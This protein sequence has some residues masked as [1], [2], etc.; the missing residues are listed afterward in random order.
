[1]IESS[2]DEEGEWLRMMPALFVV[3]VVVGDPTV[4][5]WV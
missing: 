3:V 4:V 5:M 2:E 1:L